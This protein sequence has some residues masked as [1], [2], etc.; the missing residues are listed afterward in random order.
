MKQ[1]CSSV[2]GF[3]KYPMR[4]SSVDP[5]LLLS[6]VSFALSY[7]IK[8]INMMHTEIMLSKTHSCYFN[9]LHCFG[10]F[11]YVECKVYE[12]SHI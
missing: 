5:P 1:A 7:S 10:R 4:P 12:G 11:M 9:D 8:D 6:N 2:L 3:C